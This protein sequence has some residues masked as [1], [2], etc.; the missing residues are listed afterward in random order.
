MNHWLMPCPF[1]LTRNGRAWY[2]YRQT[3]FQTAAT[4]TGYQGGAWIAWS[5]DRCWSAILLTDP[6]MRCEI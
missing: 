2:L 4:N 5:L 1:C 3:A 6:Q